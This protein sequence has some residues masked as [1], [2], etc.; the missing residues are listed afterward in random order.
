MQRCPLRLRLGLS[1]SGAAVIAALGC[2]KDPVAPS[3][4]GVPIPL[5][6]V[7]ASS[8]LLFRYIS[9]GS[10]HTCGVTL[11]D[12]AYCWGLNTHGGVGDGTTTDRNAPVRVA[13]G[14]RL[15]QISAG[16]DH[17]CGVDRQQRAYCWGLNEFGTLG[18]G[19][20]TNRHRP[21]R[22]LGNLRFRQISA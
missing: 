16:T 11:D 12:R 4:P 2:G 5:A 1:L 18:D 7:T 15:T 17:T 8:P 6:S 19:S 14:L 13:R 3:E 21:V 10:Y 9:N 20:T 22:V